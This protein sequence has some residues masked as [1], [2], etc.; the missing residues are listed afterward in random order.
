MGCD[1]RPSLHH[2][3]AARKIILLLRDS[4]IK[5]DYWMLVYSDKKP[6][7]L[8]Q[9]VKLHGDLTWATFAYDMRSITS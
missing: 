2:W 4:K 9:N 5:D 3:K 1:S 8:R 6:F 7:N